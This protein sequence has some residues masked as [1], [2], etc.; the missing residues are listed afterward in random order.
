MRGM[1]LPGISPVRGDSR[2]A[3]MPNGLQTRPSTE[4]QQCDAGD[5]PSVGEEKANPPRPC[6]TK[7][8]P[9]VRNKPGTLSTPAGSER[10][11]VLV[12]TGCGGRQETPRQ[13]HPVRCAGSEA[14]PGSS[15]FPFFG[16][17]LRT[18]QSLA[19]RGGRGAAAAAG[20]RSLPTPRD[21]A[22][23]PQAPARVAP[24]VGPRSPARGHAGAQGSIFQSP[25][26]PP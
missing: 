23:K 9:A 12:R 17:S 7:G 5:N 1:R 24:P 4:G 18:H 11:L 8:N 19:W 3:L 13:N 25:E 21:A 22:T 20:R 6:P 14:L 10:H 26:Y 16:E 15:D 2:Q